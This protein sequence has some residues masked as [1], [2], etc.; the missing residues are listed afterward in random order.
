MAEGCRI[1]LE[2]TQKALAAYPGLRKVVFTPF[3][4]A[5][6]KIY[7]ETLERLST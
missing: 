2:E 7:R 4:D 1:A 3:G 5:A 6:T